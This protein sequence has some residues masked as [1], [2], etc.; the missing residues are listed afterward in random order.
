MK[1]R[2]LIT[3]EILIFTVLVLVSNYAISEDVFVPTKNEEIYGTW[4]N[5]SYRAGIGRLYIGAGFL[6]R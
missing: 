4:V 6:K 1:T 3:S 5:K 2:I